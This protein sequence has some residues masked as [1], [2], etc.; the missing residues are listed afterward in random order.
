MFKHTGIVRRIDETGRLVI[1]KEVRR[2]YRIHDGDPLEIGEGDNAIALKKYSVLEL[3]TEASRK[4]IRSFSKITDM[5]V[6]LCNTVS[7]LDTVRIPLA[8]NTEISLE[9]SDCLYDKDASC[10]GLKIIAG[11]DIKTGAVERICIN[12]IVEGALIIPAGNN[13]ITQSHRDCLKLCAS[14]IAA[15]AE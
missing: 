15:V 14:A 2:K 10:S 11:T 7:I 13:E 6:V 8:A 12:G 1:P 9:L 4:I 5:P 3:S